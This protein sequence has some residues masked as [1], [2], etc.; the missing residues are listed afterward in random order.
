MR[1]VKREKK[2][3]INNSNKVIV[4]T[5]LFIKIFNK[6]TF[7]LN[8]F[9]CVFNLAFFTFNAHSKKSIFNASNLYCY[10]YSKN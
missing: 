9:F 3:T 5:Q 8:V 10:I 2:V 1:P 6:Y 4:M 7:F